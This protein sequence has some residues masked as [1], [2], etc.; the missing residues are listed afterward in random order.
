LRAGPYELLDLIGEGGMGTVYRGRDPRFDRPVAVKLLH[1]QLGRNQDVVERFKAEAVIQAKLNHPNIVSVLDF[2][3]DEQQFAIVMEFVEGTPLDRLIESS[4]GPLAPDLVATVFSQVLSGIG[5]AHAR[6]LVH[7]DLKPSNVLVQTFDDGGVLAKIADFGVAKILGSEKLRTAT[8]AKMGT[9]AY[10]SPEHLRSPKNVDAR[11][12]LYSLGVALFEALTGRVP[13]DADT[14]YELMRQI[15]ETPVPSV[16]SLNASLPP[17]F[18]AIVSRATAKDPAHRF[19]TAAEF[20]DALPGLSR[21]PA[22]WTGAATLSSSHGADRAAPLANDS[23]SRVPCPVCHELILRQARKCP[24]CKSFLDA[25]LRKSRVEQSAGAQ[26]DK[27][28]LDEKLSQEVMA[29]FAGAVLLAPLGPIFGLLLLFSASRYSN[30]Y[31]SLSHP[32][33]EKVRLLRAAGLV[34]LGVGV[35]LDLVLFFWLGRLIA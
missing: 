5:F 2:V 19:Q 34:W 27:V 35:L 20:K 10:M 26:H 33:P 15:V 22:S 7:R 11:S 12:D 14:E 16:R 13:F 18:D 3:A 1:P 6:G 32:V 31:R 25:Q 21:P 9:L 30:K 29:G 8:T 4:H 24:R 28:E 23:A 17:A